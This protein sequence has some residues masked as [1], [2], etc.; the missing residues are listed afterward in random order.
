MNTVRQCISFQS[1]NSVNFSFEL[2]NIFFRSSKALLIMT[3]R[4]E[5]AV[6]KIH[7]AVLKIHCKSWLVD[8][9]VGAVKELGHE[10]LVLK[11]SQKAFSGTMTWGYGHLLWRRLCGAALANG[12]RMMPGKKRSGNP[13]YGY[14]LNCKN[15]RTEPF[16]GLL[17]IGA[18]TEGRESYFGSHNWVT[19]N[20]KMRSL[21]WLY[22]R[23]K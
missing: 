12:W 5:C 19:Q 9:V 14:I 7:C 10:S 15:E 2:P 23:R 13:K 8:V 1:L 20:W 4:Q 11:V 22:F 17:A 6:V 3:F 16:L 21:D 18:L